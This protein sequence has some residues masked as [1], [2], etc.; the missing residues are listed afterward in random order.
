MNGLWVTSF[1]ELHDVLWD[2]RKGVYRGVTKATY[3]LIPKVGRSPRHPNTK[4]YAHEQ[5]ML[6]AFK[7]YSVPYLDMMKPSN[8]WDWLAL[9]QHHGLPT[10]LLDWTRSPLVAAWFAVNKDFDGD[11][12]IYRFTGVEQ[13]DIEHESPFSVTEVKRFL[14][15]VH[16]CP[17]CVIAFWPN[18]VL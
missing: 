3:E 11:S 6:A 7:N 4:L 13:V 1:D 18:S 9:G 5:Q 16:R 14:P 17:A 15:G 10:R 8:D 12:A 2:A